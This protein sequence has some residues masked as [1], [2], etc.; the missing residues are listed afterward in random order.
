MK[1]EI[2]K[3]NVLDY[4]TYVDLV[5]IDGEIKTQVMKKV[6]GTKNIFELDKDYQGDKIQEITEEF[7][8]AM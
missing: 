7:A 8:R 6:S 1:L 4:E 3:T 5:K 2:I